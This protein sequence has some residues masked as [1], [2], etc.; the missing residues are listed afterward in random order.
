MK[1][2]W[3][4]GLALVTC[5]ACAAAG[6]APVDTDAGASDQTATSEV[7]ADA[8]AGVDA[9]QEVAKPAEPVNLLPG[10]VAEFA[11]VDGTAALQLATPQGDE[12]F[13]LVLASARL[14][15]VGKK[16][17]YQVGLASDLTATSQ[18][19]VVTGC[20]LTAAPWQAKPPAA[21]AS[22]E[23]KAPDVGTTRDFHVGTAKGDEIVPFKVMAVGKGAVVWADVSGAHPAKL[24]DTF[25]KD[26]LAD[27][28]KLILP[29]ART[30]FG[31]ESDADK[32]GHIG[33]LFT[34]LTY[35]TAVAYFT[36]C[37]LQQ[38]AG[39][40]PGNQGEFLYLTPPATIKPPYNT[41]A[42]IKEIL[43]HE[44]SH[45]VHF[46][47]KVLRN[48]GAAWADSSYLIEGIGGFSQDVLGYQS[49][50]LY[51]AKAGLDKIDEFGLAETLV[52]GTQY[53]T[54]RDGVLRGGSY[55]FV[56][57]LY[58]RVGGDTALPDGTLQGQGGPA[59]MR[60][61]LDDKASAAK[62]LAG[63][64][65][66]D[67]IAMDFYTTLAVTNREDV[68][69]PQALNP[70]FRFA[71]VVADP[72]TKKPRGT[73]VYTTFHGVNKMQGPAMQLLEGADGSLRGGGVEYLTIKAAVGQGVVGIV[74]A[75]DAKANA[76]LRVARVY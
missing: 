57:W 48:Q 35:T 24:D 69:G 20:A 5:V 17:A 61:L 41:P 14:D 18:A 31:V 54:N 15:S 7:A 73:H 50:N 10:E 38:L 71:P 64:A 43:A 49:G 46:N 40:G 55:L 63:L 23:G 72:V 28:D 52:D 25:V 29:R 53:I 58:D 13:V 76:R 3:W 70:C 59:L 36:G 19:T 27:F 39:C 1:K 30:V 22:P 4:S 62:T 11:V 45:L 75:V 56:R 60:A 16:F 44:L 66:I 74:L 51:V 12:Q 9:A 2:Y 37:D 6:P 68:A 26:F 32:D 47:R 42:A 33:L 21:E 8:L 65:K 34:P 67:D